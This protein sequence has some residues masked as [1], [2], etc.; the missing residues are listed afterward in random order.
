MNPYSS[1][2]HMHSGDLVSTWE[3]QCLAEH[4]EEA[5][6]SGEQD[7]PAHWTK[8]EN[9]AVQESP[10][11]LQAHA[12]LLSDSPTGPAF[13]LDLQGTLNQVQMCCQNLA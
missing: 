1:Y 10:L 12:R 9:V 2:T 11:A 6:G 4:F 3:S 7:V 13:H 8:V 5:T